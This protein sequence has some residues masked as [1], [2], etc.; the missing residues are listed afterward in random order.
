MSESAYSIEPEKSKDLLRLRLS[1]YWTEEIFNDY[2]ARLA[3][4]LEAVWPLAA[5]RSRLLILTDI[6]NLDVL[7]QPVVARF[8]SLGQQRVAEVRKVA[9]LVPE[10][11]LRMMQTKRIVTQEKSKFFTSEDEAIAWLSAD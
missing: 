10:G 8:Q 7:P 9:T 5:T 2:E 6:R 4:V 3:A 11:A 1:G